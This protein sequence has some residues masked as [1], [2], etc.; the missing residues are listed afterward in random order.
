MSIAFQTSLFD[1]ISSEPELRPL[2]GKKVGLISRQ[3]LAAVVPRTHRSGR[4][5]HAAHLTVC[6]R[7][8]WRWLGRD[9]RC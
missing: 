5:R 4:E 1:D 9:E 3:E 8:T 2:G 7:L 6:L